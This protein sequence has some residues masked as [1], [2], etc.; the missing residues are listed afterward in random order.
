MGGGWGT[1]SQTGHP[2]VVKGAVLFLGVFGAQGNIL[3]FSHLAD[4]R[5]KD[6]DTVIMPLYPGTPTVES[7]TLSL[8]TRHHWCLPYSGF[9][10]LTSCQVDAPPPP[11]PQGF[12]VD[13]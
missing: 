6:T 3:L 13:N 1:R 8:S 5:S 7:V 11:H 9:L 12:S 10:H 2:P 4:K